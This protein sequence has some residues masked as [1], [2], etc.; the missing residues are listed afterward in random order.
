MRLTQTPVAPKNDIRSIKTFSGPYAVAA[1][2]N[3]LTRLEQAQD[4][5]RND[6]LNR[7][8]FAIARFVRADVIPEDW[9]RCKLEERSLAIGLAAEEARR[10]ISSAFSAAAIILDK[11]ENFCC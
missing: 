4:G 3:E 2:T 9:A 10:T 6:Q 5:C 8:A 11:T 1:I 7:S